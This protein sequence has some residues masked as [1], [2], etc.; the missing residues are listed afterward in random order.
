MK[1]RCYFFIVLFFSSVSF[2]ANTQKHLDKLRT[3]SALER[4][5]AAD[6]LNDI[7]QSEARDSLRYVGEKLYF[8]GI[9]TNYYPAIEKGKIILSEYFIL[10]GKVIDGIT[11]LKAMLPIIEQRADAK[12]LC[13]VSKIISQGY[14]IERDAKSALYWAEKAVKH[15]RASSEKQLKSNGLLVLSEAYLLLGKTKKAL[16]ALQ[17]YEKIVCLEKNERKK[18][19]V[20]AKLG[21][22]FMRKG[23]L[24]R[25]EGY[26]LSSYESA[27]QTNLISPIANALNNLA[28]I[29]F[30]NNDL[31]NSKRFFEKALKLRLQVNDYKAIS[32]SYYNLGDFHYYSNDMVNARKWYNQ[33]L[34]TAINFQLKSEQNDALNAL[35]A[36]SKSQ[37]DYESANTYREKQLELLQKIEIDNRADEEEIKALQLEMLLLENELENKFPKEKADFG[38][39]WEWVVIAFLSVLLFLKFR[40]NLTFPDKSNEKPEYQPE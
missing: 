10:T 24:I 3:G 7:Y 32:E 40:F 38:M 5:L 22:F 11:T 29:Y 8:F 26:F 13:L 35:A 4:M 18:S 31:I 17:Q 25:A 2:A 39:R 6:K 33:S 34:T 36:M 23:D 15:A 28:I 1:N 19:A 21:D 14:V 9:Q 27:K 12:E 30:E 37:H 20:Y 16:A